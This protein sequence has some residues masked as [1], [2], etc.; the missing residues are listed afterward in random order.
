MKLFSKK[1]IIFALIFAGPLPATY[2][3]SKNY[4]NL[5]QKRSSALAKLSGYFIAL[6][7]YFLV[8]FSIEI[9]VIN[10]GIFR[11]SRFLGYSLEILFFLIIHLIFAGIFSFT[12]KK[13]NGKTAFELSKNKDQIY[14]FIHVIPFVL[15][16][17]AITTYLLIV[18]SFRFIFLVIYLLPN[19]YL[20]NHI[21]KIF[22]SKQNRLIFT[23]FFTLLVALFPILMIADNFPYGIVIKYVQFIAYYYLP[24]LLYGFL[25]YILFDIILLINCKLKFI[26]KNITIGKRFRMIIFCSILLT[27]TAIITKGIINFNNT[28]I[29]EYSIEISKKTEK[30]EHLKIVMAADI[31][32]SEITNEYFVKQFVDKINSLNPDIVLFAGDIIDSS[33]PSSKMKLFESQMRKIIS[34]YGVYAVDGNHELYSG[35][36]RFDFFENANINVLRDTV[37]TIE[38]SFFLVGRKDRHDK[39]RKTIEDLLKLTSDSLPHI[40]LDHQPYKLYNAYNNKIDVQ[41]S[42]HTHNGQLFPI[43]LIT[44]KIYELSWGYKK[45]KNTHFF[46]TCG[47]QGWG[48]QV[49]TASHSE[50]LEINIDFE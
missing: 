1:Q 33:D 28:K 49:K 18:G 19:V 15:L 21:T 42:G 38:N 24:I 41:L 22:L 26:P 2:L 11:S 14:S 3:L 45:I 47:A 5:D 23:T 16:G 20:H 29:K 30:L 43:N 10:T 35:R 48:P 40:L 44:D 4:L 50:I 31:H 6:L 34:N 36:Y 7:T 46:V 9:L 32:L 17:I 37:I 25:F 39:D 13:I 12:S 27:T 8:I